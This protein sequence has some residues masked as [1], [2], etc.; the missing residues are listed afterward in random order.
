[1]NC[2]QSGSCESRCYGAG[3][4]KNLGKS[5]DPQTWER[6]M[7]SSTNGVFIDNQ[8]TRNGE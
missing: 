7:E 2:I 3:L 8:T 4:E 6:V 1:M 5:W